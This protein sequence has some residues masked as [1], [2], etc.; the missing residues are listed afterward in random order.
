MRTL[1]N[2][3]FLLVA[4]AGCACFSSCDN[5]SGNND[6][7]YDFAG[8]GVNIALVDADGNNLLSPDTDGN[9]IGE[10]MFASCDDKTYTVSWEYILFDSEHQS[11]MYLPTFYGLICRPKI[12]WNGT[13]WQ[14]EKNNNQLLFGEFSGHSNQHKNIVFGI[15]KLNT[16]WNIELDYTLTWHKGEPKTKKTIRINGQPVENGVVTIVL[17]RNTK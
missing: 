13:S 8:V 15:D 16:V 10:D 12:S 9:W 17:P 1:R 7:L 6:I 5:M 4:L 11:R 2:I 3:P 14:M